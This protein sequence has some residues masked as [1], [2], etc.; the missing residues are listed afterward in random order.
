M[1]IVFYD[2][3]T[4]GRSS[5]WDQIIQI[6]AFLTDSNLNVIEKINYSCKINSYIIPD[7]EALLV[8]RI[9]IKNLTNN[10]QSYYQLV[11][12]VYKKFKLW[13]PAIFI[14]YNI[15]KFDE[16]MLRN[17]FFKNLY[18][19]YLTIKNSNF[20]SD[21]L[22]TVRASNY[23][24][25][26][27]IKS[28][29]SNKGTPI[30]KLDSIAPVNGI[31]DF[32]AHDAEGDVFAT[33][34]I[35]KIIKNKVP[36]FWHLS[37]KDLS[38]SS[39]ENE[40]V[41]RPFCFLESYFGKT[42]GFCLSY[43]DIHPKYKWALCFDLKNDPEKISNMSNLEFNNVLEESPKIIRNL[44]LNKSPLLLDI[45]LKN[46]LDD[47]KSISEDIVYNRHKFIREN[48]QF[49]DRI[50]SFFDNTSDLNESESSQIDIFAEET[51]YKKFLNNSDISLLHNFHACP[52]N[53]K[54]Y[55]I[56]KFHDERLKYFAEI[57]LYEEKPEYL[58]KEAYKRIKNHIA[59]RLLSNN[60]EKWLTI[61]DAY[62]KIDDLR[63]KYASKEEENNLEI[64]DNINS[65]IENIEKK[66]Q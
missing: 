2:L 44:K 29:V 55:I 58:E 4:T 18:D 16:E 41:N 22:D 42:K 53:E 39:I 56:D 12:N 46:M 63:E 23:F 38:K 45:T 36:D 27:K 49:K 50:I 25:P 60:K 7:P 13:S 57:M 33:I 14:G 47:Y 64:L 40:I 34:E 11:T 30:L 66:L 21:L 54:K 51:I 61:Y 43:I 35:A 8:N 6:A 31:E 9:P 15:I 62:K 28:L 37:T 65:Y 24:Y 10:N 26:E 5:Y 3:E 48:K 1:N 19:P 20:R 52:W 32:K 59:N 17:A